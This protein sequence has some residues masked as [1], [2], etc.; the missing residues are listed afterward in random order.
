MPGTWVKIGDVKIP[1]DIEGGVEIDELVDAAP[2]FDGSEEFAIRQAGV[3]LGATLTDTVASPAQAALGAG[4]DRF[5]QFTDCYQGFGAGVAALTADQ[6][7]IGATHCQSFLSGTGA[8]VTQVESS[9]LMPGVF[10]LETGTTTGG[11]CAA[12]LKNFLYLYHQ[13]ETIRAASRLR[14][15]TLSTSG[16]QFEMRTGFVNG[17]AGAPTDG[18]FFRAQHGDSNFE[19][20]TMD[21]TSNVT[22]LDTGVPIDTAYHSFVVE[23]IGALV[24]FYIDDV[25]VGSSITNLPDDNTFLQAGAGI[26]KAAG[27]TSR[28]LYVDALMRDVPFGRDMLRWH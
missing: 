4:H 9:E 14:I 11:R 6:V 24:V 8:Q 1:G 28:K 27:T 13:A 20:V 5:R 16:E 18:L 22:V 21:D 15:P 10:S 3:T 7:D 12:V 2:V 26:F 23:Q 17:F 19:A 25:P